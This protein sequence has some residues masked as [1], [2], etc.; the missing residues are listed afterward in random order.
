VEKAQAADCLRLLPCTEHMP[1]IVQVA[2]EMPVFV[3][4]L[5]GGALAQNRQEGIGVRVK[6]Y[7][8]LV[9][10]GMDHRRH[11]GPIFIAAAAATHLRA[12]SLPK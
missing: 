3:P 2:V 6:R 11:L 7:L 10:H 8:I 4:D 1:H 9:D 12:P 5:R